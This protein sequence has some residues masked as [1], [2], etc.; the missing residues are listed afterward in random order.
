MIRYATVLALA[1][2]LPLVC[3]FWV[4]GWLAVDNV[5]HAT[6]FPVDKERWFVFFFWAVLAVPITWI[7]C[8]VIAV[9]ELVKRK[10]IRLLVSYA[11]APLVVAVG[12]WLAWMAFL[13]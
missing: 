7:V 6:D 13:W 1:V 12:L 9:I 4:F 10:R 2:E 8:L 3:F 5:Y 11:V